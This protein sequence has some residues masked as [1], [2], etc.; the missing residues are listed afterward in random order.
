MV[1]EAPAFGTICKWYGQSKPIKIRLLFLTGLT[2]HCA[3]LPNAT[4]FDSLDQVLSLTAPHAFNGDVRMLAA[5]LRW[6]FD[7]D[8]LRGLA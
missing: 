1:C 7:A 2:V 3:Y 6:R 8:S 5:V 4:E